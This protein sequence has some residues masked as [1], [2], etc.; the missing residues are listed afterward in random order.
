MTSDRDIA[1]KLRKLVFKTIDCAE[2]Y[3]DYKA[4]AVAK[5]MWLV[6]ALE[7][8]D[9]AWDTYPDGNAPFSDR[10]NE[11]KIAKGE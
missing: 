10:E 4:D 7:H 9:Y 8:N 3:P 2:Y 6:L 1:D 5:I 11:E